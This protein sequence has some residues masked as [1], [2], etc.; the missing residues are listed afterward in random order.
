MTSSSSRRAG[1]VQGSGP[2]ATDPEPSSGVGPAF[3]STNRNFLCA[4]AE[5]MRDPAG[6]DRLDAGR[7]PAAVG[8]RAHHCP[9][10][11]AAAGQGLRDGPSG[12]AGSTGHQDGLAGCVMILTLLPG[13]P[14][15]RRCLLLPRGRRVY[16]WPGT[17]RTP[18]CWKNRRLSALA[19]YS[20]S[21]PSA[22]RRVSVPVKVTSRPTASGEAPGKPPR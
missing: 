3:G 19:Q 17:S 1:V 18:S 14:V 8:L 11:C 15:G 9:H 10:R 4:V 21:M 6:D 5:M 2:T 22:M 12:I 16:P 13:R 7:Q 20:A